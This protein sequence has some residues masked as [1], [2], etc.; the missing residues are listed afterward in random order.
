[1][2]K[3]SITIERKTTETAITMAFDLDGT[4][5]SHIQTGIGF[6]DHMLTLFAAHGLFNLTVTVAGD[7]HVDGHHT[8]EDV[9]IC[10]GQA[11]RQTVGD[12]AGI[13]RYAS[14]SFPMDDSLCV[15]AMD[16]G[17]RPYLQMA[18]IMP[19]SIGTFDTEL[20]EEFFRSVVNH[21]GMN[22][23]VNW[24]YKGNAH[25]VIEA[26]FKGFGVLLDR[27]TQRDPRRNGVP[28][29]KGTL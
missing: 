24:P 18:S 9:G 2:K 12:G 10:L 22:L 13:Y 1:M 27:A 21:A 16:M 5:A 26:L 29:T 7:L 3:R 6:F 8:V 11:I 20:V 17:G 23:Y 15:I 14:G 28:S 19:Q 25:H 4:G